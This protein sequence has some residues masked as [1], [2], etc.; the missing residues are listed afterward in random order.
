MCD[1]ERY[2]KLKVGAKEHPQFTQVSKRRESKRETEIRRG[3]W[4][5]FCEGEWWRHDGSCGSLHPCL[6]RGS[7]S[8]TCKRKDTW[9][10]AKSS[11]KGLI[12]KP[13]KPSSA[14]RA[15]RRLVRQCYS[16]S[17]AEKNHTTVLLLRI[18][19][20]NGASPLCHL[21]DSTQQKSPPHRRPIT[22]IPAGPDANASAGMIHSL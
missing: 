21:H 18:I 8:D 3:L 4:S 16:I 15:A 14:H 9:A 6:D 22:I 1:H 7:T 2:E 13:V 11:R 5:C 19:F 20:L 12:T 17:R 10:P